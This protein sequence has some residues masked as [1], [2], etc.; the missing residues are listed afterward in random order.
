MKTSV[1]WVVAALA[2]A[3]SVG[4]AAA[5]MTLTPPPNGG[6]SLKSANGNTAIRITPESQVQLPHLAPAGQADSIVCQDAA[7]ILQKCSM[8]TLAVPGETGPTGPAGPQGE[9][10]DP[11]ERG[12]QG[13]QGLQGE[14][15]AQGEV[16]P[17]GIEGPRGPAGPQ[18]DAGP[19]GEAG[20]QGAVGPQGVAGPQG[21]AGPQGEAGPQGIQGLRGETGPQGIPGLQGERGLQGEQGLQGLQGDTG[22]QG[23]PGALVQGVSAIR[24]GC[25]NATGQPTA[26]SDFAVTA[27][28]SEKQYAIGFAV[29]MPRG[30]Y[31]GVVDARSNTGR[32]LAAVVSDAS[33][34]G[35]VVTIGWLAQAEGEAI[36]SVCFITAL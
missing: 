1:L 17:Q 36:Q 7:G 22:P 33:E 28:A 34:Q 19:R 18:G 27:N 8:D 32:S 21:N 15:G 25:F 35:F 4:A 12:A 30:D 16:G 13:E 26:G 11:G 9:K 10:G 14:A 5:D 2:A 23:V 6:I 29:A 20:L 24:H 3:C 31:S